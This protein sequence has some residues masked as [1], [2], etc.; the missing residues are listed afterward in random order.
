MHRFLTGDELGNIKTLRYSPDAPADASRT[1]T[2]TLYSGNSNS[3]TVLAVDPQAGGSKFVQ[4]LPSVAAGFSD[5]SASAFTLT[6][7]DEL[8][9]VHDWRE[10]RMRKEQRYIGLAVSEKRVFSCTS[11]GALRLTPLNT[12]DQTASPILS[13]LPTR[14]Y[15]W[16]MSFNQETFAYG[17]DEVDLSLWDTDRAFSPRIQQD[18]LS[19]ASGSKKRK[20]NDALFP[21]EI[22]RAKNVDNDNLGLRQ[23]VRITALTFLSSSSIT[24]HLAAGTQLGDVRRYDTR[25]ARRP[26]A[27]WKI[28]KV[29][30]IKTVEKGMSEHELFVSDHGYNL[31]AV[32]LRNGSIIYGYKGLSGAVSS[33]A[34]S[35][36][37]LGSA[38]LDRFARIHSTFPPPLQ[39]GHRQERKG[40][41]LE[42][43]FLKS[44]PTVIVWDQ[45]VTPT[46]GPMAAAEEDDIWET[47]ENIEDDQG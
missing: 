5:G 35:P 32:D 42:K 14:L 28:G 6:D 40:E 17:G 8:K 39:A 1:T 22:W 13:S 19:P 15:D 2:A 18:E 33:I 34:P 21:G 4:A 11:N 23:P 27:N 10:T 30:G 46:T 36:S 44:T 24:H 31:F 29:G 37:V 45:V 16:R 26:V 12:E 25:T 9:K 7:G 43:V 3:V 47:M 20:R 41:V 38:S